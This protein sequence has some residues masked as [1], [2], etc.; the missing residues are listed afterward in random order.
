MELVR[1]PDFAAYVTRLMT[2]HHVPGIAVAV[3]QDDAVASAGFGKASLDP[4]VECT[5]ESLFDVASASKSLTAAAVALLVDDE[6][7]PEV[8]YDAPMAKLLP[9][10]IFFIHRGSS[11]VFSTPRFAVA[12][13]VANRDRAH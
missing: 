11:I 4:P 6:S 13:K 3:V 1:T 2:R 7:H 12:Y 10:D 5:P 9:G 8:Q